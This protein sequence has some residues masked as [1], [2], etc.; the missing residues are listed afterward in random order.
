MSNA[1]D[2]AIVV[3]SLIEFGVVTADPATEKEIQTVKKTESAPRGATPIVEISD[4]NMMQYLGIIEQ[5]LTEITLA[6]NYMQR[7]EGTVVQNITKVD[8][9]QRDLGMASVKSPRLP[10]VDDEG[11][12]SDEVSRH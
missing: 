4:A 6:H 11:Y 12:S 8:R 9:D 5:Q 2:F 3:T 7:R 10:N 1:L